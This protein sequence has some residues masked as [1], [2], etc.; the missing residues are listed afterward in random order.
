MP[1]KRIGRPLV[2][3][4]S[5]ALLASAEKIMLAEGYS[6][7]SVDRVV[8]DAGT[9]RPTFYK[10]YPSVSQLAFEV[11]DNAF[12]ADEVASTGTLSGDL[13][14]LQRQNIVMMGSSLMRLNLPGLLEAAR[15]D[16]TIS[17]LYQERIL[18]PRRRR[19]VWAIE[20][21]RARGEIESTE[22]EGDLVF[23]LLFGPLLARV[24]LPPNRPLDDALAHATA[25]IATRA[26]REPRSADSTSRPT[27][28]RQ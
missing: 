7:L 12:D 20:S 8:T 22:V 19:V 4:I 18:D 9:T 21:A 2:S 6:G 23:D 24:L 25:A 5:S 3:G 13:L 10:R 1:S 15:V 27:A 14:E 16:D 17:Q 26:I 11:I 28:P